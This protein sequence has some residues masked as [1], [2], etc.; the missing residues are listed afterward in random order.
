MVFHMHMEQWKHKV[1]LLQ[2]QE[3]RGKNLVLLQMSE[4]RG[5]KTVVSH[6]MGQWKKW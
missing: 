6:M 5:Q 3:Q 4:K 1:V 2:V